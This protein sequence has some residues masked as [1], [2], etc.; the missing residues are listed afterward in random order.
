FSI[1]HTSRQPGGLYVGR[2]EML[3]PLPAVPLPAAHAKL[4]GLL[5]TLLAELPTYA[6]I[7]TAFDEATWVGARLTEILPFPVPLRQ[8]VLE[9][10]DALERLERIAAG[11]RAQPSLA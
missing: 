9:T 2:V 7:A 4:A 8:G 11:L 10:R 5:Q 6:S 1:E 3:E